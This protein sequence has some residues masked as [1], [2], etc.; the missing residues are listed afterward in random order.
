MA[1]VQIT[2]ADLA[3]EV[4]QR[5][6]DQ[7]PAALAARV[8]AHAVMPTAGVAVK[9]GKAEPMQRRTAPQRSGLAVALELDRPNPGKRVGALLA[10]TAVDAVDTTYLDPRR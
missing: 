5:E 10:L 8:R 7:Q 1:R 3:I 9:P 4:A 2:D 6:V